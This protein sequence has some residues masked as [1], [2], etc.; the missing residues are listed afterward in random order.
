MTRSIYSEKVDL[1]MKAREAMLSAVQ[2]YNNPLISFK[3]ESYIVL[4]LIAWTYLL[5]AYYRAKGID[6]RYFTKNGG[7]KKY[8]RNSDGSIKYWDLRECILKT[9]C[10]LDKDTTNNLSFLIGLRNQIEH[11]KASGLD[12]YLS[13][14]YQACALNLN[15][16]LKKLHGEKY[17]LD[18]NLAL[19]LQFSE[20]DQSQ[21]K[22]IKDKEGF[23]PQ[24]VISYVADFDSKLSEDEAKSDRFAYR[25]LFVKVLAKR[26]GQ[27]DRVI[28]F[29]D[30]KSELA[31]NISKEY[32]IKEET[33][34]QKFSATLVIQKVKEAGFK[35]F[36]MYQHI[37]F[38]RKQD[39]KN[40]SKGFGTMII[41]TW[42]WYQNWI[43]YIISELGKK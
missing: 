37:Q 7:R 26:K 40:I 38:W 32:W 12:S 17:G 6:Y 2:I 16:Y 4:S 31:K 30:P 13:A 22:V 14:R 3:T 1:I 39:G 15:F 41:K 29:I 10:P 27:A 33:E 25:L 11:R 9:D 23:I 8:T 36:G 42:Y 43:D 28:E 20:L 5:H 24:N 35:N 18:N 19:S 21:S 34:K